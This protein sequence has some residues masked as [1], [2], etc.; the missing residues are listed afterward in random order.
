M[1]LDLIGSGTT[2]GRNFIS[3]NGFLAY[4]MLISPKTGNTLLS[5]NEWHD[6]NSLSA[7]SFD[8]ANH[9]FLRASAI[10]KF[11]RVKSQAVE[12]Y[13]AITDYGLAWIFSI[14]MQM[15]A[16]HIQSP[17]FSLLALHHP[18]DTHGTIRLDS[19][20]DHLTG[21]WS[22]GGLSN[23]HMT[24][25]RDSSG[26]FEPSQFRQLKSATVLSLETERRIPFIPSH[27][28]H[29][30]PFLFLSLQD[31]DIKKLVDLAKALEI[32]STKY[33]L[34]AQFET[35]QR[36]SKRGEKCLENA[37]QNKLRNSLSLLDLRTSTTSWTQG[38]ILEINISS[39]IPKLSDS[40]AAGWPSISYCE[41]TFSVELDSILNAES[42]GKSRIPK[43]KSV[44]VQIGKGFLDPKI[45]PDACFLAQAYNFQGQCIFDFAW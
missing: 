19:Q 28:F 42:I 3:N 30:N 8:R 9:K 20:L 33:Q 39:F 6:L 17:I 43:N 32:G 45:N 13:F 14:L 12:H 38:H 35:N 31:R 34:N 29:P 23:L 1:K 15:D 40:P 10:P 26:I 22:D 41:D 5:S 37:C 7:F 24:T 11:D 25:V 2:I 36:Y 4:Q 21:A 27:V 16:I 18:K 44:R